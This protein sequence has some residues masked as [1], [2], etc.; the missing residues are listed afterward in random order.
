MSENALMIGTTERLILR[1][2]AMEDAE[3]I[4]RIFPHWEIVRH[5][6][7]RVPWPYPE[8]GAESFLRDVA[9]PAMERGDEWNW[10][11]RLREKPEELIGVIT[12]RCGER[13]NRGFWLGLEWQGRGLMS[14]AADWVTDYWFDVLGFK[15]MRVAKSKGNPSS[16]RISEKQ[17]MRLMG[18]DV[19]EFVSGPAETDLWELTAEEWRRNRDKGTKPPQQA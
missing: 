2:L 8:D 7:D 17:G 5:L 4:L 11:L 6:L 19:K 13:S 10:S 9:L 18:H 16:R 1:P 12:L 15:V 14:E 3:Q